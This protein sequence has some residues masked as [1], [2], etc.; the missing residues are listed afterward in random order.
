M[1]QEEEKKKEAKP[2]VSKEDKKREIEDSE[3]AV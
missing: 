3:D 2:E 1:E